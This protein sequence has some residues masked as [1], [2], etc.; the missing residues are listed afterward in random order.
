MQTKKLKLLLI[1]DS[2][3]DRVYLRLL[4]SRANRETTITFV[5]AGSLKEGLKAL[6]SSQFDCLILDQ[7][8]PDGAG[9]ELLQG[10]RTSAG[11]VS[12][13][14][15]FM[16][17]MGDE[18]VAAQAIK[19][20]ALEYVSKHQLTEQVIW[21]A[22]SSA[23]KQFQLVE[24][25]AFHTEQL[26]RSVEEKQ[27]LLEELHHRVKN[28]LQLIVSLINL[29]AESLDDPASGALKECGRR[30]HSI[31]SVYERL[32]SSDTI[33][34]VDFGEYAKAVLDGIVFSYS[35]GSR[36]FE[37]QVEASPI[38]LG[39]DQAIPCG[40]ILNELITNVVKYAYPNGKGL[41]NVEIKDA[42][43]GWVRFSVS[44]Q[45]VGLPPGKELSSGQSLGL[46]IVDS[47]VN[48]LDG[49]LAISSERGVRTV[50]EFPLQRRCSPEHLSAAS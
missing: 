12:V 39:L 20:G 31:A 6:D 26:R 28:N 30:V 49:T 24:Q 9:L 38:I 34:E 21:R 19:A 33:R 35:G 29:Q 3:E 45:G 36:N 42:S 7:R 8:L 4:L 48:Q 43:P 41:V 10:L 25:V 23:I 27:L 16:T 1:D 15:V 37:G 18:N 44:D 40:L 17:G 46:L 50:I 22:V 13:P 2:P 11:R 32:Q 14:V 5:E 47:L